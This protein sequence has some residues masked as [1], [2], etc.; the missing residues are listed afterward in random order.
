ML[1]AKLILE[2][3]DKNY[4]LLE[5]MEQP[6]RSFVKNFIGMLYL[7]HAY[8]VSG[9]PYAM[10]DTG[11]TSRNTDSQ[12]GGTVTSRSLKSTL[13]MGAPPGTINGVY[14][15]GNTGSYNIVTADSNFRAGNLVGIQVGTG[16]AAVTPTN[17]ALG[18]RVAHGR[19]AGQL[20]Y[21]GCELINITFADPNGEFTVRRYFTN[22]SGGSITI[23]EVGIYATA[24]N[25][26]GGSYGETYVFLIARDLVSPGVAVA[27]AELLRV[28]YVMQIT[29]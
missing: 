19:G 18:T 11:N 17:Y 24:G 27:D 28:T 23:N 4:H 16:T 25:A 12:V 9:S 20:E 3:L 22:H 29:V 21:G 1:T 5:K 8:V 2:R 26:T 14:Y 7:P 6:S 13:A 10:V 15:A